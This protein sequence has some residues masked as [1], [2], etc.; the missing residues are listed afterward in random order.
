MN[1]CFFEISMKTK[2]KSYPFI[3]FTKQLFTKQLFT[4]QGVVSFVTDK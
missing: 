3:L 4:K 2:L 1:I